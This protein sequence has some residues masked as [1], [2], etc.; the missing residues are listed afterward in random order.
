[1]L[2]AHNSRRS[3]AIRQDRKA[4][5]FAGNGLDA[6]RHFAVHVDLICDGHLYR[7]DKGHV[8]L[9]RQ[10]IDSCH[11]ISTSDACFEGSILAV[12]MDY[13][14]SETVIPHD[15]PPSADASFLHAQL[16][17]RGEH[18]VLASDEKQRLSAQG[19]RLSE[20]VG[21]DYAL[22]AERVATGS[23]SHVVRVVA[24]ADGA[25]QTVVHVGYAR[26]TTVVF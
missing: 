22:Q 20:L 6:P 19:T 13:E 15:A 12:D 10:V 7:L 23:V 3:K 21:F 11:D 2:R 5:K 8:V 9:A 17:S 26:R 4:K 14:H 16:H 1:M 25:G 18:R 24:Q